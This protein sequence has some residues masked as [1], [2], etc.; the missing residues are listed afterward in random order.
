MNIYLGIDGVLRTG[1]SRA[2]PFADDFLQLVLSRWPD[3]TYWLSSHCWRGQNRAVDVLRPVLRPH[4]AQ[5]IKR[6]RPTDWH[7]WKTDAINWREPFLWFDDELF[8]EERQV[9]RSYNMLA[10]WIQIDLASDPNQLMDCIAYLRDYEEPI[11]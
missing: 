5:L 4:T 3:T 1:D 7:E 11:T 9:L 8:P 6:V 2:A 10:S